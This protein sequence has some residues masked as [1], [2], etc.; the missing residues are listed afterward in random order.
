MSTDKVSPVQ[1]VSKQVVNSVPNQFLWRCPDC[2]R[3]QEHPYQPHACVNFC[4][5][6]IYKDEHGKRMSK[7]SI[8]DSDGKVFDVRL[9]YD[10]AFLRYMIEDVY[11]G[12]AWVVL[13]QQG[14]EL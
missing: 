9:S 1:G 7:A 11:P 8:H 5:L 14:I 6:T 13:D 4:A 2:N 3:Q 10:E 12:I